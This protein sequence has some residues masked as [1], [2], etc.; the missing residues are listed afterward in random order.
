M[1]T[2]I[3]KRIGSGV[4]ALALTATLY[5]G[6]SASVF[7]GDTYPYVGESAPG[8]NQPYLHVPARPLHRQ[9][10]YG[11]FLGDSQI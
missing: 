7:A 6:G 2:S 5:V 11:G 1:K 9:R 4:L 10:P 8:Y 3:G